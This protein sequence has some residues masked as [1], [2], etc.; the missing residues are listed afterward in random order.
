MDLRIF[1]EPQQ[2]T[3]YE[4]LLALARH[5][6]E[7]GFDAFFTSDHLLKMGD[8]D[9]L[10]GPTDAWTTLAGLARDTTRLRL[11][12]LVT[13]V[14]FR[15]PGLLAVTVAQVDAMSGGRVELGLGTG[16]YDAEHHAHGI[17]FP[18]LGTRFELLTEALEV[19]TGLWA[20][21]VG[22]T[23]SYAG[24][25]LQI[26]DGPGLPKPVQ[27]PRPPLVMGGF[28]PRRTPRLAAR[29]ADEFNVPFAGPEVIGERRDVLDRACDEIGRDPTSI[30]RSAA[31]VVCC[32]AD[33]AEV[34]RRAAAIG[35]A[36]DELR[37]NGVAGTPDEC[38]ERL[39]ELAA[40][41]VSRVYLQVLDDTDLEHLDLL[42]EAV[43]PC[44]G[45][46]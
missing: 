6:E 40:V 10:P 36:P 45:G 42:A 16:W 22:E 11:G 5:A 8:T 1:V 41:G 12:T 15:H 30:V 17:P 39:T 23:F 18:P 29:F 28:G 32:G 24:R 34:E 44:V 38:V 13:P 9:G 33:G 27:Q 25:H 43:A 21:P 35:R 7:L 2:G 3:T 4:R 19:V 37:A 14:T 20:T 26:V 46:A 31:Q